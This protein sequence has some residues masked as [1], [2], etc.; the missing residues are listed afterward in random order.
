MRVAHGGGEKPGKGL[1]HFG[2][3]PREPRLLDL[4]QD[5]NRSFAPSCA[6]WSRRSVGTERPSKFAQSLQVG[7][8]LSR[9]V[10]AI[11]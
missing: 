9:A 5:R 3:E 1:R 11:A 8:A 10:R 7:Q 2:V 4:G 6:V